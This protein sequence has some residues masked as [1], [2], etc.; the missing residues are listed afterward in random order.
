[1]F[2]EIDEVNADD[3]FFALGG[4]SLLAMQLAAE[5][6]TEFKTPVSVGE[7]IV[8]SS[9]ERLARALFDEQ[10][11]EERKA[12]FG[13]VLHLRSGGRCAA[14]LH[15]SRFR[16]FVGSSASCTRYLESDCPVIG[17]QSPRPNGVIAVCGSMDEVLQETSRN[18]PQHTAS[19]TL[20]ASRLFAWR[21]CGAGDRCAC[22]LKT[23][24]L[25]DIPRLLDT[26]PPEIQDWSRPPTE[27]EERE[28]EKERALFMNAS[29]DALD[30]ALA[31]EK[32]EMFGLSCGTTK[33]SVRLLSTAKTAPA[34]PVRQ[35]YS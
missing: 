19:R 5:L 33:D 17:L 24:K 4:H 14:D 12:G 21:R 25:V 22:W 34:I 10:A 11:G 7:V 2:L 26:Y 35:R 31:K 15:S 16:F 32:A 20:S 23:A 30:S 8:N 6:E 28:I 3:D 9:V 1:M 29:K 27:D 13:E 18:D